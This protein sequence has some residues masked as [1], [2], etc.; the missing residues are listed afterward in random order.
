M[1][2]ESIRVALTINTNLFALTI[3]GWNCKK[4]KRKKEKTTYNIIG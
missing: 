2:R 1:T 3:K 4:K